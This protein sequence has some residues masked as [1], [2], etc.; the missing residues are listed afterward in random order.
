MSFGVSCRLEGRTIRPSKSWYREDPTGDQEGR[1]G[2]DGDEHPRAPEGTRTGV[3]TQIRLTTQD[4]GADH[5]TLRSRGVDVDPEVMR[6]PCRCS[7]S[8]TRMGIGS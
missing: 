7:P 2:R 3:D 1:D 8:A 5:A 4:A 6:Y